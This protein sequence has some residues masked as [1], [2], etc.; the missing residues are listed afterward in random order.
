MFV[1]ESFVYILKLPAS[2]PQ[3]ILS[4]RK[5]LIE[6]LKSPD[7]KADSKEWVAVSDQLQ[8]AAKL[9]IVSDVICDLPATMHVHTA[10]YTLTCSS[11]LQELPEIALVRS[12]LAL[13]AAVDEVVAQLQAAMVALQEDMLSLA[14]GQGEELDLG[15]HPNA[16]YVSVF[17][18]A[19]STY[20]RNC[21]AVAFIIECLFIVSL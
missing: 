15:T 6:G 14:V 8:K 17:Q 5:C 19:S 7:L 18:Q 4:L 9:N 20:V 11:V 1:K 13:R 2:P 3:V 21:D 16:R 10:Q 12:E